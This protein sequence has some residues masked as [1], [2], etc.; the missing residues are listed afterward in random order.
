MALSSVQPGPELG[1]T[2]AASETSHNSV[3][4]EWSKLP[5]CNTYVIEEKDKYGIGRVFVGH[6]TECILR[7]LDSMS[8]HQYRMKCDSN[9]NRITT[10]WITVYTSK[11][12]VNC[13]H[14]IRACHSSG[15]SGVLDTARLV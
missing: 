7:G 5:D 3:T 8:E 15:K 1:L 10:P 13:E 12:P 14:V 11:E 9:D 2:I 6:S 4:L